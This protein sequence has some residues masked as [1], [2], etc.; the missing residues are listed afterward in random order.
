MKRLFK[1]FIL[2]NSKD[3]FL[4]IFSNYFFKPLLSLPLPSAQTGQSSQPRF[5]LPLLALHQESQ[6][7]KPPFSKE[8]HNFPLL[9]PTSTKQFA[10]TLR[11]SPDEPCTAGSVWNIFSMR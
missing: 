9:V 5:L 2:L 4:L 8:S 1:F 10:V 6:I 3:S 11:V 7:V